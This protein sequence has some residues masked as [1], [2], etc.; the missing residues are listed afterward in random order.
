MCALVV[1]DADSTTKRNQ[2][3]HNLCCLFAALCIAV[4]RLQ[5]EF[6]A[7]LQEFKASQQEVKALREQMRLQ[8]ERHQ[9]DMFLLGQKLAEA[10]LRFDEDIVEQCGVGDA[11]A[12]NDDGDDADEE[13][14]DHAQG[15]S[16][17]GRDSVE[18]PSFSGAGEG[19]QR[20]TNG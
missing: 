10:G 16:A 20:G 13:D 18:A 3:T 17:A 4:A 9:E 6:K 8:D 11:G 7:F 15:V 12:D 5:Q 1:C 14:N 2:H 19:A